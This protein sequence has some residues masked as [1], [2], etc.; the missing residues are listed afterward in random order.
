MGRGGSER[1][2][3]DARYDGANAASPESEVDACEE[4]ADARETAF[5]RVSALRASASL[6]NIILQ[7][8]S[9]ECKKRTFAEK[10]RAARRVVVE[11]SSGQNG[12]CLFYGGRSAL[13]RGRVLYP[14]R[15][16]GAFGVER[17][18]RREN[19]R[20]FCFRALFSTYFTL[21]YFPKRKFLGPHFKSLKKKLNFQSSETEKM[22]VLCVHTEKNLRL[23]LFSVFFL[24]R[25]RTPLGQASVLQLSEMKLDNYS[26][27]K[28]NLF[29]KP[30]QN[31]RFGTRF[32]ICS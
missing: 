24:L 13:R 10:N 29:L 2:R 28:S 7:N 5:R 27:R 14:G 30:A 16:L 8:G 26:L 25:I 22:Q 17:R 31:R 23:S 11:K 20:H 6:L 1:G 19:R 32:R 4:V 21:T 12:V 3:E 15:R 9:R 18:R